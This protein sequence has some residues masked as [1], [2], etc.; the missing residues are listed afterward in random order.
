MEH[1]YVD[2]LHLFAAHPA[3]TYVVVFLAAFLEA[4]IGTLVPG[5]TAM[6]LTGALVGTGALNLRWVLAFA[7]AGAVA[8][9]SMSYW[10]SSSNK[11]AIVQI[12]L[13][14]KRLAPRSEVGKAS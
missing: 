12:W 7:I 5:S 4:I 1:A 8:G 11:V 2:M 3:W 13:F 14:R 10:L 6:F 9:N